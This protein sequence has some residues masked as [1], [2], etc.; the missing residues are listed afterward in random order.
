[1]WSVQEEKKHKRE[2]RRGGIERQGI[3]RKPG[4][5]T[6]LSIHPVPEPRMISPLPL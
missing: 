6:T 2:N 1:L 3:S 5:R 4:G